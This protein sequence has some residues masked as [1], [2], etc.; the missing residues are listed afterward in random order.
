MTGTLGSGK[1]YLAK[2]IA[3]GLCIKEEVT[4]PT[5][6]IVSEYEGLIGGIEPVTV[7]HI[8]AYRLMGNE[9]FSNIGGD[10]I[11]S[12]NGVSLIEWS[13][14]ISSLIPKKALNIEI[15]IQCNDNRLIK[16]YQRDK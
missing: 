11:I 3:K 8:D 15:E 16:L 10:E 12:G 7:Y 13:E 1:T 6:T 2:G 4:S 14:R 9:D 5:Y